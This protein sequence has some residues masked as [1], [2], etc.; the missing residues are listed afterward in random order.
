M[1]ID[2]AIITVKA[3]KGGDGAATFR[4]EKYV[5]FGGPDGGDGGDDK[6]VDIQNPDFAATAVSTS[7]RIAQ[8]WNIGH[9][10]SFLREMV[11]LKWFEGVTFLFK[12][13]R[14]KQ[15]FSSITDTV[16]FLH[17]INDLIH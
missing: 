4:R 2:E 8:L 10:L 11:N 1:F 6:V 14:V 15:L 7:S 17:I 12:C 3:G 9:V 5:Q 16:S 13:R